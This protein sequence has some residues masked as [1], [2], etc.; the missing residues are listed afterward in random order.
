[1]PTIQEQYYRTDGYR[2]DTPEA[3]KRLCQEYVD[4]LPV[5]KAQQ[6]A[7]AIRTVA[8]C[9]S[10]SGEW[11]KERHGQLTVSHFGEIY[12]RRANYAP[13]TM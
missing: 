5:N 3:L 8:Q 4:C 12:K 10:P 6:Q 13:P 1:M 11:A 9:D 2:N 7:M